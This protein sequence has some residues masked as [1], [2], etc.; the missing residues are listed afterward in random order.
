MVN[1]FLAFSTKLST[2]AKVGLFR[3]SGSKNQLDSLKKSLNEGRIVDLSTVQV[4]PHSI[5]D[6]E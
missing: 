1:K 3:V 4:S 5:I 2:V 6:S